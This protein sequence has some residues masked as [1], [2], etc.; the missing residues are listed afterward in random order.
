MK[1]VGIAL[2]LIGMAIGAI[3]YQY[4]QPT[5]AHAETPPTTTEAALTAPE[6]GVVAVAEGGPVVHV[7]GIMIVGKVVSVAGNTV[8]IEAPDGTQTSVHIADDTI[9]NRMPE[10]VITVYSGSGTATEHFQTGGSDGASATITITTAEAG[11]PVLTPAD[12]E[13]TAIEAITGTI[14]VI[15][16]EMVEGV[17]LPA[18]PAFPAGDADIVFAAPALSPAGETISLSDLQPG[19]TVSVLGEAD[20]DG[21]IQAKAVT[22]L[23][24]AVT[25][26]APTG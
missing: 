23:P 10:G 6:V 25:L 20:A 22:V 26:S 15:D 3:G 8:T 17:A 12:A 5:Q 21:V 24:E 1:L 7:A 13:V 18:L 19:M 9:L 14:T 16:G 4:W 2:L 11:V